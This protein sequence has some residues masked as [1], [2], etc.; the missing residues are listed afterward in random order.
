MSDFA[1]VIE[2]K[3]AGEICLCM[4]I[5]GADQSIQRFE[6]A[7]CGQH[8]NLPLDIDAH[9]SSHYAQVYQ[10]ERARIVQLLLAAGETTAI[11]IIEEGTR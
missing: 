11:Q 3:P 6:C 1:K 10:V 7:W 9:I 2:R 5:H 8:F 4:H